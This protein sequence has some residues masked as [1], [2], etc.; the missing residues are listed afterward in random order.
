MAEPIAS[1]V[2]AIATTPLTP[3]TTSSTDAFSS[4]ATTTLGVPRAAASTTIRPYPSRSEALATHAAPANA[5]ST[6]SWGRR[7]TRSTAAAIPSR[8]ASSPTRP[9]SGPSPKIVSWSCGS[10][11]RAAA[12]AATRSGTRFSGT[13]RPAKTTRCSMS[14]AVEGST[15]PA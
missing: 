7:P 4:P 5:R 9:R 13:C 6:S 11:R 3:G 10:S 15:G 12:T 1:G 2:G 8:R 14:P